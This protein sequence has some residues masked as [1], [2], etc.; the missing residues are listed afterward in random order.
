M[1]LKSVGTVS[2]AGTAFTPL[3][4]KSDGSASTS[5]ARAQAA[6]NVTVTAEAVTTTLV[7]HNKHAQE[8]ATEGDTAVGDFV[9]TWEPKAA[10]VLVGAR[11]FYVQVALWTYQGY[12][13]YIEMPTLLVNPS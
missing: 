12:F 2:S 8:G 4:L 10:P 7:H 1:A 13:D 9:E 11:C 5:T 6:G 3:P